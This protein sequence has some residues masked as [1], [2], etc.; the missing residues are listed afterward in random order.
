MVNGNKQENELEKVQM[1]PTKDWA[2]M[3]QNPWANINNKNTGSMVMLFQKLNHLRLAQAQESLDTQSYSTLS[4]VMLA[5]DEACKE[6]RNL[7]GL[8][9]L[10]MLSE[11]SFIKNSIHNESRIPREP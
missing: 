11:I 7:L 8:Q 3:E 5:L 4:T 10:Q 9:Q 1:K 2:T 6:N